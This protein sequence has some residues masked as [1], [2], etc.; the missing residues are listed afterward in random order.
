MLSILSTYDAIHLINPNVKWCEDGMVALPQQYR[1]RLLV[2][3]PSDQGEEVLVETLLAR[4]ATPKPAEVRAPMRV[5]RCLLC[6][7]PTFV[8]L[9]A[10]HYA[11]LAAFAV[12]PARADGY[13]SMLSVVTGQE[14]GRA[15]RTDGTIPKQADN[16]NDQSA[17]A[18]DPRE[19]SKAD[20]DRIGDLARTDREAASIELARVIGPCMAR[21]GWRI[22]IAGADIPGIDRPA[23]AALDAVLDRLSSSLPREVDQH[24]DLV[25]VKRYKADVVYT[26]KVRPESQ[27]T[28][29]ELRKFY[30]ADPRAAEA[31]NKDLMKKSYCTTPPNIFLK[32][33]VTIVWEVFDERGLVW[34]IRLASDDCL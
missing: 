18:N 9:S 11:L 26:M 25:Q 28:A 19:V 13:L 4:S 16:T 29:D 12:G 31:M 5:A 1:A 3:A 7:I 32:A 21:K 30:V 17:C 6:R 23:I 10:T 33:G 20:A 27:G 24:S 14:I 8:A 34:R 2:A 15:Y 22:V